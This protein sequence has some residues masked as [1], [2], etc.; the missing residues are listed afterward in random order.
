MESYRNIKLSHK[1]IWWFNICVVWTNLNCHHIA[2]TL[3]ASLS[4]RLASGL[5]SNTF[6]RSSVLKRWR[7]ICALNRKSLA[8][9]LLTSAEDTRNVSAVRGKRSL[10]VQSVGHIREKI[11]PGVYELNKKVLSW[12]DTALMPVCC[13]HDK[14]WGRGSALWPLWSA[15][16]GLYT[17]QHPELELGGISCL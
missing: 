9:L 10:F 17:E 7:G 2:D 4:I 5:W 12:F 6:V 14:G 13:F 1:E 3:R 15:P 8:E 11:A 16:R